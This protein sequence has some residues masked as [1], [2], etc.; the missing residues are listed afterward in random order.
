M[1]GEKGERERKRGRGEIKRG[2]GEVGVGRERD[3]FVL[4]PCPISTPPCD[5]ATVPSSA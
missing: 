4:I 1:K 5:T 2:G 3:T